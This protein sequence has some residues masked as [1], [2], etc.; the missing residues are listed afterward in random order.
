MWVLN[1][2]GS[3]PETPATSAQR[4]SP[5]DTETVPSE[6]AA[7]DRNFDVVSWSVDGGGGGISGG[8]FGL[9]SGAGEPENGVSSGS[10]FGFAGGLWTTAPLQE[11]DTRIFC[12]GFESGDTGAWSNGKRL[13]RDRLRKKR[14]E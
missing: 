4:A 11:S 6:K 1:A 7:S 13:G 3:E 9:I 14:S 8:N 10:T 12:D 5:Q 2:A